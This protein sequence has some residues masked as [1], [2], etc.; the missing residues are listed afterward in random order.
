VYV[1]P[2]DR[3]CAELLAEAVPADILKIEIDDFKAE[4]GDDA[5]GSYIKYDAMIAACA[6]RWGAQRLVSIDRRMKKIAA[7]FKL[8]CQTPDFFYGPQRII[9]VPHVGGPVLRAVQGG[10]KRKRPR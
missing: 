6:K 9:D 5:P 10:Q 2:F 1:V 3:I 7:R 8:D 4:Y